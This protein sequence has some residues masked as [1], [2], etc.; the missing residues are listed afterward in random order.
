MSTKPKKMVAKKSTVKEDLLNVTTALLHKHGQV[1]AS[2]RAICDKVGVKPPT[3]YYYYGELGALHE[4]AIG[5][6]FAQTYECYKPAHQA[7]DALQ[8]IKQSWHLFLD[9]AHKNPEMYKILHVKILAGELPDEVY[10][11]YHNLISDLQLYAKNQ[12]LSISAEQAAQ[13][14]WSSASGAA[15]LMAATHYSE[16]VDVRVGEF[17]L[18][19]NLAY[20]LQEDVN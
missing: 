17:M 9:F 6:V 5:R 15:T 3:L 10:A 12:P 20:L 11:A 16:Y 2:I 8:S 13:M 14:I 1:G 7:G 4:Q 18:Q 19:S